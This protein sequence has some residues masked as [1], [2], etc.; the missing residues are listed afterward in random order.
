MDNTNY[1][2][3][4]DES[5]KSRITFKELKNRLTYQIPSQDDLS[6]KKE[7]ISKLQWIGI[8]KAMAALLLG[9]WLYNSQHPMV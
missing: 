7:S 3:I 2:L 6:A 9:V 4:K 5:Q 8:A 1:N